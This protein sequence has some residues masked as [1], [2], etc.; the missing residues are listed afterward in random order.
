MGEQK[1]I[2][3]FDVLNILACFCVICLHCNGVVHYLYSNLRVWYQAL[4]IET[5]CYWA[6]PVFFMLTGATLLKYRQRYDTKEFFKK[7]VVRT[8]IPWLF[9]SIII[10]IM[11]LLYQGAENGYQLATLSEF[12]S[13]LLTNKIESVY[14]FFP[15]LFAIY[16]SIPVLS[17]LTEV[18]NSKKIFWYMFA[19]GFITYS[20]CP[21][22]FKLAQISWNSAL[23]FPML[24]GGYILFVVLGYLLS[25]EDVPQK[26][27]YLIYG[28]AVGCIVFRYIGTV[29]LSANDG[30]VN[31]TLFGYVQFHSVILATAVFLFFKYLP[32]GKF[33][34]KWASFLSRVSGCSLG[35]YLIHKLVMTFFIEVFSIQ[36]TMWEWRY[37]APFVIYL[38]CLCIVSIL[39]NIPI[40]K[41]LVP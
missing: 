30:A 11:K 36:V 27:R 6:V 21:V 20:V 7:R 25:K 35:I 19:V 28:L 39:K 10:Y 14:W 9:W 33:P 38:I 34:Q 16:L 31:K 4:F 2:V 37:L 22:I 18:E 40:L 5:I 41:N 17:L 13:M 24:G 12:I 26:Y 15:A 23:Q 8:L 1:R 3:Y 32:W 29:V